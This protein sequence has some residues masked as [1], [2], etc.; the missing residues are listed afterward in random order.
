MSE[1]LPSTL[2]P[3]SGLE[4][5]F[6]FGPESDMID[7]KTGR[8]ID[9]FYYGVVEFHSTKPIN[10]KNAICAETRAEIEPV[11]RG[12]DKLPEEDEL[13]EEGEEQSEGN[14]DDDD[15]NDGIVNIFNRSELGSNH[16]TGVEMETTN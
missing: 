1:K 4:E 12:S 2:P 13:P 11:I 5:H 7:P 16:W 14:G 15:D 8:G 6:F 9:R 10:G 3:T